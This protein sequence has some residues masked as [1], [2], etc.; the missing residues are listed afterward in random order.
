MDTSFVRHQHFR[1]APATPTSRPAFGRAA[2]ASTLG[3]HDSSNRHCP[4]S[5]TTPSVRDIPLSSRTVARAGRPFSAIPKRPAQ[6][7]SD[8]RPSTS[9]VPHNILTAS[10]LQDVGLDIG[11]LALPTDAPPV[12]DGPTVAPALLTRGKAGSVAH[13]ETIGCHI[14]PLELSFYARD[15]E[16]AAALV[17][18]V[19]GRDNRGVSSLVSASSPRPAPNDEISPSSP[20]LAPVRAEQPT[21]SSPILRPEPSTTTID[22][23]GS[24]IELF[25]FAIASPSLQSLDAAWIPSG[26]DTTMPGSPHP[27]R[28]PSLPCTSPLSPPS[29]PLSPTAPPPTLVAPNLG[30]RQTDASLRAHRAPS[31]PRKRK[32]SGNENVAPCTEL[33]ALPRGKKKRSSVDVPRAAAFSLIWPKGDLA[34]RTGILHRRQPTF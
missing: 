10:E 1:P 32:A 6:H 14:L 4:I 18:V 27:R 24:D 21:E 31:S 28:S 15:P 19:L 34:G 33:A 23:A 16:L 8:P 11:L 5:L 25:E 26:N 20:R 22:S 2:C 3:E 7:S 12:P 13:S 9:A 17:A 30:R 29:R